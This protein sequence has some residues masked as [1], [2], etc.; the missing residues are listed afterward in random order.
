DDNVTG[1]QSG[2]QELLDM[3]TKAGTVDWPVDDAGGGD[4]VMAQRRQKGQR[5]PAAV[6][7]FGDQAGAMGAALLAAGAGWLCPKAC[8]REGGGLVEEDQ[9]A[10]VKPALVF[11]PPG[12]AAGDVG[13]VLFAGV[14]CFF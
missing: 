6:R 2:H 10:R 8:P 12:P 9:A 14:Q 4:P 11:L 5:A 7:H 13:A 1:A 3:G